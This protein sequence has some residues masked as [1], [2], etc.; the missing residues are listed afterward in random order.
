MNN[1]TYKDISLPEEVGGC[2][3]CHECALHKS[4]PVWH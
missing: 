4:L 3:L 2:L 1:L